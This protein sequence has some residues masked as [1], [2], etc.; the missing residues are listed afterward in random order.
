MV[1]TM[2]GWLSSL[3]GAAIG[4]AVGTAIMEWLHQHDFYAMILPGA[5]LGLGCHAASPTRSYARGAVAGIAGLILGLW[6]DWWFFPRV[7]DPT[8]FEFVGR[9][10]DL[11]SARKLMIAGGAFFAFWWGKDAAPWARAALRK[12]PARAVEV[13]GGVEGQQ[14]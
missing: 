5:A 10:A 13:Q 11:D 8:F 4:A 9:V 7:G 6:A 12:K 14:D 2:L 1:R 3:I